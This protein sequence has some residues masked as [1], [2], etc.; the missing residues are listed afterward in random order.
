MVKPRAPLSVD[1][2]LAR[3]AGH[4]PGGFDAMAVISRRQP[5]TVRN[6]SD[7]DR[8]EQIPLDC[9]IELDLAYQQAGGEG[10]PLYQAY[11]HQLEVAE[12]DRFADRFTFARYAVTAIKEGGE[13]HAALARLSL[14]EA[15]E[16]DHRAARREIAEAIDALRAF[17]LLLDGP[18]RVSA[19]AQPLPATLGDTPDARL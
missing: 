14:P 3:I 11:A 8:E 10:Y 5:R 15:S 2:A 9:A 13:A 17:L 4:L 18:T 16:A 1:A 19:P 12:A 7:P 6:W